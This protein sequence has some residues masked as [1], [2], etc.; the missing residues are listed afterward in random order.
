MTDV[1]NLRET[2]SFAS[3]LAKSRIRVR[4]EMV[5][6]LC[7]LV[8]ALAV[9]VAG[10]LSGELYNILFHGRAGDVAVHAALGLVAGV[11]YALAAHGNGLYRP[12]KL[13][14]PEEDRE[15]IWVSWCLVVLALAMALVL[16]RAGDGTLIGPLGCLFVVG[17]VSLALSRRLTR[18]CLISALLREAVRGPR[19]AVIGAPGELAR[20]SKNEL[21][22]RFGLDEVRRFSLS[23]MD[24]MDGSPATGDAKSDDAVTDAVNWLRSGAVEEIVLALPW[25]RSRDIEGVLEALRAL[26]LPVRLLPDGTVSSLLDLQR[27]KP[28]RFYLLDLQRAPLTMAEC[29][30]KRVLDVTVAASAL[31]LL[32]PVLLIA[33]LAIKLDSKGPVIFRQKRAGFNGKPFV[34]YKL[35][36]MKVLEDGAAVVQ[37]TRS[38]PR[39]TRVGRVLR[40]SSV[41]EL[42]QL[43]NVLQGHMSFVGPRP[44]ALAHDD[45]YSK[46]IANY[47]V[48]HHVKP[49]ITGWAQVQG[50]RGETA[51]LE[52]M[53]RRIALDLWYINNW[54]LLL[55]VW[56]I[57]ATSFELIRRRNA[58]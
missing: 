54:T 28:R 32:S 11:V 53:E 7:A 24:S 47:A 42:P 26:P 40:Q 10:L 34:I 58:Y 5:G 6:S 20:L 4:F 31:V 8:D 33:A 49:G 45:E 2:N 15:R 46:V 55:D 9:I 19:T 37:A 50:Y 29:L 21:L 35:R 57:F 36:T 3:G 1:T 27:A 17:A 39:V 48:R 16:F 22:T 38:D 51:E 56:I 44:H 43:L 14:E 12:S 18:R 23:S 41:D 30:I 52:L 13:L 25:W